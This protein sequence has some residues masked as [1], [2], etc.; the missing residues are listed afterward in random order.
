MAAETHPPHTVVPVGAATAIDVVVRD[1]TGAIVS[2]FDTSIVQYT[3]GDTDTSIGGI[4]ALWEDTGDTLR[5]ASVAKPFPVQVAA[6][7][8][9]GTNAIGKLGANSG[10]DIGDVDITSIAAGDN[11]IGNVDVVTL[12]NV[13]VGTMANLTESLV[14]DA[15][16]TPATSRVV[17][18]GFEFDDTTPDS[19]NEGDIGAG[20]MSA[21]RNQYTTIRDA[22][23]NE[24]GVNINSSN[25]LSV[26]VD[27]TVTSKTDLTPSAPTAASVGTSSAQAVAAS[28]TRTGLVLTNT[29]A[30]AISLGFGATAVLNSGITLN[31]GG[32]IFEMDEYTF[33]R[34]AV[35]AIAAGASSNLAIQ[36][37]TT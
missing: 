15:A 28:A 31:A 17:P 8:P 12:P 6:A 20:R 5:P 30:N 27:N 37:Y 2:S 9:T 36:E 25:Q 3:E 32:G 26:S 22:A 24:R 16:F 19:V 11:N 7:L 13:T 14:D 4:A 23:G 21:N 10:V 34:G 33:D 1:S 35:N 18:V 29:S